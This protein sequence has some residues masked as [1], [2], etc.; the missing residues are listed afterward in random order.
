MPKLDK[1]V[2][3]QTDGWEMQ[4]GIYEVELKSV[5]DVN[6]K[7]KKAYE[8]PSGPYWVWTV[9]FP[10][11]A[12]GGKYAK[13]QLSRVVS[14][15]EGAAGIRANA[16]DAFGLKTTESTDKAIGRRALVQVTLETYDR[17]TRPKAGTFFPIDSDANLGASDVEND[18]S[19]FE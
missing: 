1:D 12:N 16:F 17:V 4:E 18:A 7:T 13:R 10:K 15:G 9:E 3:A 8:G 6:P 5:D 19:L 11:D 2:A 14:L